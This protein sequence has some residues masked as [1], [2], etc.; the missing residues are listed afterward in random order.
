[1]RRFLVGLLATVGGLVVSL[2]LA[3]G[4]AAWLFWPPGPPPLPERI[5]L[6]LDLR[7][8]LDEVPATDPLSAFALPAPTLHDVIL[9]LERA[10]RDDRVG[11]LL[12]RLDGEGLGF[13][14]IQELR[15]A[16]Q[17]FRAAGRATVAHAD[18]FG[19]FG[20]GTGG[21]YLASAFDQIHL[22]P[23]GAVGLTGLLLETPLFRGV[24]D[25]IG[26]QPDGGRRGAYKSIY[27]QFTARTFTPDLRESMEGLA[28][29]LFEQLVEDLAAARNLTPGQVR[30]LIDGGPYVA[31]EALEAGLVDALSYQNEALEAVREGAGQVGEPV[32]LER[33]LAALP[34]ATDAPVVALVD[35]VGQIAR[36]ESQS[37]PV[38]SVVMGADTVADA[39]G[40]AVADPE[41]RVILLRIDSGGGSA[42]ASET[43]GH[44]VR[45]AAAEGKPVIASMG[46]AA[47]SGG[48]WIAMDASR[49]IA[50]PGT[51]TGSIGVVIGKPVL[52][53]L[54]DQVGLRFGRVSRGENASMWSLDVPFSGAAE[55]R[56]EAF[57][58][59]TYAAFTDGVARGRGLDQAA[60]V[61]AAEGR[62]WTG[63][64]A[65]EL[66]LVDDLGGHARALALA[67]EEAGVAPDGSV[68]FRAFPRPRTPLEQALELLGG[69]FAGL[70]RLSAWLQ[71]L[72]SGGALSAPPLR[73]R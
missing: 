37:G 55:A 67:R 32:P 73:V 35:A 50:R 52:T 30:R 31:E 22:Q 42:V 39:I 2:A 60:V 68:V 21:Y 4:I 9:A 46:D 17:A 59:H 19:E 27:E 18:S 63:Q 72:T 23:L 15:A 14:Q 49:I 62:V 34:E 1:V 3:G 20:P 48:Y 38:Q 36:G 51:L 16:V 65:L 10:A 47:A 28:T 71:A 11:G 57:L 6:T 5:V 25:Q 8:G 45:Q 70:G 66:G 40:D 58:D 53:E 64:Q 54:F 43:I 61:A 29:S 56:L 24:L 7:D 44:A 13:A 69:S 41:V 26:I 33:Y 12:V